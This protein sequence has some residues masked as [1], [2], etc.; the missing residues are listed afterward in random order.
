MIRL[1]KN[2]FFRIKSESQKLE[3]TPK[4]RLVKVLLVMTFVMFGFSSFINPVPTSSFTKANPFDISGSTVTYIDHGEL[5]AGQANSVTFEVF[6]NSPDFE[7][8]EEVRITFP[9]GWTVACNYD[10]GV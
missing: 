6:N 5:V 3:S 1:N 10:D 9:V 8:I 7:W 4:F 2:T